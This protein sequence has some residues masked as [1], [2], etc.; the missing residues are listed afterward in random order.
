MK[1]NQL[2]EG[3]DEVPSS[4]YDAADDKTLL[5]AENT[6][7]IRLTL[8]QINKLRR[9]QEVRKVE[10]KKQNEFFQTIYNQPPPQP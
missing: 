1:L 2:F 3:I 10:Q 8:E 6:R 7:K 4:H 5:K 9:M